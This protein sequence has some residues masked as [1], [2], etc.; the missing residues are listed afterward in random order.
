MGRALA[1][2]AVTPVCMIGHGRGSK[3][4]LNR[5]PGDGEWPCPGRSGR[6]WLLAGRRWHGD[7]N[8]VEFVLGLF[9]A[10]SYA[11]RATNDGSRPTAQRQQAKVVHHR[12][13]S[14]GRRQ[15]RVDC[16]DGATQQRREISHTK[17]FDDAQR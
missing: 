1:L 8:S 3:A 4:S 14:N 16:E 15:Q 5:T 13:T 11:R 12:L 17:R 10:S 6:R 9:A 7:H 2:N